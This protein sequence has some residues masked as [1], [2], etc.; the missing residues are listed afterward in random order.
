[1]FHLKLAFDS[2][3]K[4]KETYFP[5]L[6]AA[7]ISVA[8]NFLIQL[9]I[10]SKGVHDLEMAGLVVVMLILGQVVIG[11]LSIIILVY[12]Y[13]FLKKG[14][15]REFGLYSILGLKK[16]DLAQISFLQQ[17]FSFVLCILFGLVSG[18]VFARVLILLL[19]KMLHGTSFQLSFNWYS[20]LFTVL[21]F[22]IAFL[23]LTIIDVF[24]V[25][26]TTTLDLLTSEKKAAT[27]PKNRWILFTLGLLALVV[28]YWLSLT[29]PGP[30]EAIT[31]FF[32]DRKSVV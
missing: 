18:Y 12:T 1:M 19:I 16:S 4:N 28:G 31:R 9:L 32:I 27:A 20:I 13:S 5:F 8:F 3:N 23:I 26:K 11:I 22:F 21:F 30:V 2:L 7:V 6:L 15:Q 14:K 17:M 10:F 29:V 25:Y 24:S